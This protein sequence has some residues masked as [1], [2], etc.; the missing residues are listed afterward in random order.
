MS[1]VLFFSRLAKVSGGILAN[2]AL[3]GAK[4]VNGPGPDRVSTRPA[5]STAVSNVVKFT[6]NELV[7][8]A[9]MG[10]SGGNITWLTT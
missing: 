5:A 2:A 4:T 7:R 3:V 1:C 9:G 6:A 8:K 10:P